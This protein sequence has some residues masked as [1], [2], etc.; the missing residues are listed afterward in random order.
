M[1]LAI[2]TGDAAAQE[3][4]DLP[5]L[6]KHVQ[7]LDLWSTLF[8]CIG[9][10]LVDY[11]FHCWLPHL[12]AI[13][14]HSR[15]V[16][17]SEPFFM[18]M[19]AGG[20]ILMAASLIPQ[21]VVPYVNNPDAAC[22]SGPWLLFIGFC[23]TFAAMFSKLRRINKIESFSNRMM[24]VTITPMQVLA[25]FAVL[26]TLNVSVLTA[27]TI[28]A[29][30][31]YEK[32]AYPGQDAYD[33]DIFFTVSCQADPGRPAFAFYASLGMLDVVAVMICWWECYKARNSKVAYSENKHMIV[34]IA[35]CSQAFLLGAPLVIISND[36]SVRYICLTIAVMFSS[37]GILFPIMVPKI[38]QVKE[39]KAELVAKEARKQ[40]R[41]RRAEAYFAR[42]EQDDKDDALVPPPPRLEQDSSTNSQPSLPLAPPVVFK[43]YG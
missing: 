4:S 28:M 29:P 21:G 5:P 40:E 8:G 24:R 18:R 39:W 37:A 1:S 10:S 22:M 23:V 34:A 2:S 25:P 9:W 11:F 14:Y 12:D 32:V 16:F 19:V 15:S 41:I 43:P 35:V 7:C 42:V 36:P 6:Q 38:H 26:L 17:V 33:R 13:Q 3:Q 30:L 31:K 20:V 27:W